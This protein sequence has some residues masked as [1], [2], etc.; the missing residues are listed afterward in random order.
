MRKL[1]DIL[2]TILAEEPNMTKKEKRLAKYVEKNYTKIIG[3]SVHEL[4]KKSDV[5]AATIVRFCK[6][7]KVDGFADFKLYLSALVA[8]NLDKNSLEYDE[9]HP[10]EDTETIK[11]KMKT[12]FNTVINAICDELNN[13]ELQE[14]VEELYRAAQIEVFGLG[15]SKLVAED[16]YQKMLR[17]GKPVNCT[18]D[19]HTAAAQLVNLQPHSLLIVVSDSGKTTEDIDLLKLAKAHKI[20]TLALTSNEKSKVAHLSKLVLKTQS[21]GEPQIRS[22]ATTSLISQFFVIDNL[23]FN[24]ISKYPDEILARLELSREAIKKYKK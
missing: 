12:R 19:F 21:V 24:Y 13:A 17:I 11:I 4:A 8:K 18:S 14:A 1:K 16:I 3:M 10:G 5:S 6:R 22:G 9:I 20:S 23:L 15:A 7:L 2:S